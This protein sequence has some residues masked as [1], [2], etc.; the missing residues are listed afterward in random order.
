MIVIGPL[1]C[2]TIMIQGETRTRAS[3]LNDGI[4]EC[5]TKYLCDKCNKEVWLI[6]YKINRKEE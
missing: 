6:W 2:C 3:A 5:R 4:V 1:T